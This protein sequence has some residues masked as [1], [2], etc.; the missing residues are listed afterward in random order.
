MTDNT[1]T[2][3]RISI[4]DLPRW[5]VVRAHIVEDLRTRPFVHAVANPTDAMVAHE[6]LVELIAVYRLADPQVR[7]GKGTG[8]SDDAKM[9][10]LMRSWLDLGRKIE[11]LASRTLRPVPA[12]DAATE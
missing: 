9:A 3:F 6:M 4:N 12:D 11:A 2:R 10:S 1:P 7:Y 8:D 5:R